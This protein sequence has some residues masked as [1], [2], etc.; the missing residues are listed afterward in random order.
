MA[1]KSTTQMTKSELIQ[2]LS[3]KNRV[4]GELNQKIDELEGMAI[5]SMSIP[6]EG[7]QNT[8]MGILVAR[9]KRLESLVGTEET[10]E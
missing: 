10:S 7:D 2:A 5:K 9:I 8:A 1:V 3:D 4:I 6:I